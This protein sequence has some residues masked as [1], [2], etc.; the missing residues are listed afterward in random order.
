MTEDVLKYKVGYVDEEQQWIDKFSLR[1]RDS[2]DI[3]T[4]KP[5]PETTLEG[6]VKLIEEAELDCLIADFELKE[7][8]VIQFNGD[9]VIEALRTK[10]P[11][12]PV[13]IITAKEEEDVLDQVEDNE[14]VRLKN[15]LTDKT[16]MLVQR[17]KNKIENYH[18]HIREAEETIT[19]LI[20]KKNTE[21]GLTVS[22]EEILTEKYLF[23]EKI[24][25]NEKSL[26]DNLIQPKSIT[27]LNDFVADTKK[28]LEELKKLSK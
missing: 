4:I 6:I 21:N 3:T 20:T 11:Y 18:N 7:A 17:I 12:F 10:Y 25:P 23:L 26:P 16:S 24:N 19:A 28:I 1:L 5:T 9:E 13:F 27:A 15:D 8:D 14:I 22:E 2:F